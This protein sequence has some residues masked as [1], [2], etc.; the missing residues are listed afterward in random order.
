MS[1]RSGR[2][3]AGPPPRAASGS[4]SRRP[5]RRPPPPP[6]LAAGQRADRVAEVHPAA[7]PYHLVRS[8]ERDDVVARLVWPVQLDE[9]DRPLAPVAARLHPVAWP[10]VVA[11][12][13]ILV[14]GEV[15]LAL[16]QA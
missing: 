16:H 4:G 12:L 9:I 2:R 3:H 13:Q 6:A 11:G 1:P 7:G 15:P 14:A 10:Q 5:P 8:P